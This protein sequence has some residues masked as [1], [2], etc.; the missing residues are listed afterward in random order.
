MDHFP[1]MPRD[2]VQIP[3]NE[4]ALRRLIVDCVRNERTLRIIGSSHA[5]AQSIAGPKDML[6]SLEKL[7]K[8]VDYDPARGRIKVEAGMTFGD[9]PLWPNRPDAETFGGYLE[10]QARAS[11]TGWGLSNLGGAAHQTIGG[12]VSTGSSGGSV[13]H[14][15]GDALMSVELIDGRGDTQ[16][17]RR[18]DP[19]FDAVA[20]SLGLCGAITSVEFQCEPWFDV[21]GHETTT[22]TQDCEIDLCGSGPRSLRE[23]L[24]QTPYTRLLWWPQAG[25]DKVTVWQA[26]RMEQ[27]DYLAQASSPIHLNRRPYEA[28]GPAGRLVADAFYRFLGLGFGSDR[29]DHWM[30]TIT[31]AIA[32]P[33]INAFVPINAKT[34]RLFW[35]Y[36]RYGLPMDDHSSDHRLATGFTELWIPLDRTQ[37]V[38]LAL[39][40]HYRDNGSSATGAYA[41]EIFGAKNSP[42]C[43]SPAYGTDVVRVGIFWF[44]RNRA[45][46]AKCFYPQFWE[47]LSRFD[48]RPHWG[49]TLPAPN[50]DTGVTYLREQ[51]PRF[52]E[53]LEAREQFDP[54]QVFVTDYWRTHLGIARP[55]VR[56][57]SMVVPRDG[58]A[59]DDNPARSGGAQSA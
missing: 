11:G 2:H 13:Q 10:Q 51:Y 33:V 3:E 18:G 21:I 45:D 17:I 55:A 32:P 50:S 12:F 23:F 44:Q 38:M 27:A 41:C 48:F 5:V 40:D 46:P 47:L 29:L 6:V 26:R 4:E 22:H 24:A 42:F 28:S 14:S 53:F 59:F 39:R 15:L 34:P 54:D 19:Q 49:K 37:E 16:T 57:R 35:D 9:S 25:V 30:K 1:R 58:A 31:P 56:T 52:D 36:W 20:V 8:V 7:R 43:L